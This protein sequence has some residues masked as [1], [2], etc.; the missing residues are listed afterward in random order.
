MERTQSKVLLGT[1]QCMKQKMN[2]QQERGIRHSLSD[3][4]DESNSGIGGL[5]LVGLFGDWW[6][7]VSCGN[8]SV[9]YCPALRCSCT[10]EKLSFIVLAR[11]KLVLVVGCMR[12]KN[13][14]FFPGKVG[15]F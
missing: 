11:L 9:A 14:K 5:S 2:C 4:A 7:D 3:K 15:T 6:I 1:N 8:V 12:P 13:K 10:D